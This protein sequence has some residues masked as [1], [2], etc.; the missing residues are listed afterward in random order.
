MLHAG[1][2]L[3]RTRSREGVAL[4]RGVARTHV[5]GEDAALDRVARRV[6]LAV[7]R[8]GPRNSGVVLTT[9]PSSPS[10]SLMSQYPTTGLLP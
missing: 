10:L 6:G 8:V 7:E 2:D 1:P 9:V 4:L 5:L 3:S